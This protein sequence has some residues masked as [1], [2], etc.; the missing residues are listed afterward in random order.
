MHVEIVDTL[1]T[2]TI[3]VYAFN[4]CNI[5]TGALP[6]MYALALGRACAYV[7]TIM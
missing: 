7:A 3:T 1:C 4:G 5:G 2:C 6:D